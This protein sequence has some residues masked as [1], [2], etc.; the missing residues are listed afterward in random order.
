MGT[1]KND[2]LNKK[3][4][5]PI[6]Y[7]LSKENNVSK[8]VRNYYNGDIVTIL[9]NNAIEKE[10]TAGGAIRYAMSIKNIYKHKALSDLESVALSNASKEYLKKLMK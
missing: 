2:L 3:Y 5:L 6:I 7:L 8:S 1:K 10:L 4:S 9:D